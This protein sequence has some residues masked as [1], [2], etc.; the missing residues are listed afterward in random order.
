MFV[1]F[2]IKIY[3]YLY[4]HKLKTAFWH[5]HPT[6]PTSVFPFPCFNL[7]QIGFYNATSF[8]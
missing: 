4:I 2:V 7:T 1:K 5:I 6:F 3:L 8:K